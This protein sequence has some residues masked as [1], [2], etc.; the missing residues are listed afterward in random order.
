MKDKGKNYI[1]T[2]ITKKS[3]LDVC[4]KAENKKEAKGMVQ[5]VLI[6]CN[7][8]GFKSL[9]EFKFK[10]LRKYKEALNWKI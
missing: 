3:K 2:I 10:C 1:V 6:K 9:K 4:V 7:L 8:F 5:D